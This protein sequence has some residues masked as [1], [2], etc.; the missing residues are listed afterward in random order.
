MRVSV[1]K[2]HT[3]SVNFTWMNK[4]L[5]K[6]SKWL[7]KLYLNN[8]NNNRW[9]V[10]VLS[11]C[12]HRQLYGSSTQSSWSLLQ[13]KDLKNPWSYSGVNK[14]GAKKTKKKHKCN[15]PLR[16]NYFVCVNNINQPLKDE[17][18]TFWDPSGILLYTKTC[19]WNKGDV[20]PHYQ[21]NSVETLPRFAT[22]HVVPW[23]VTRER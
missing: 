16:Q 19:S 17:W 21:K 18:S 11:S 20:A 22:L 10:L 8:N 23:P 9:A 7:L 4:R 13:V 1:R 15:L 3:C 2:V 5:F 12:L 14:E 6:K